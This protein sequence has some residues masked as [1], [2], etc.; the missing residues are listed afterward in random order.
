MHSSTQ[1]WVPCT[2]YPPLALCGEDSHSFYL[3]GMEE[4]EHIANS[5][6][7]KPA[8]ITSQS[9]LFGR[10]PSLLGLCAQ[11]KAV[12]LRRFLASLRVNFLVA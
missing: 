3:A 8:Y 2:T 7:T 10:L 5:S 6:P 1:L 4:H 12:E 11:V 9:Q